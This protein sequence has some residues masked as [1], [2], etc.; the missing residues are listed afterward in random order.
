MRC[1]FCKTTENKVIDSRLADESTA[2]RR[3]RECLGC[4]KRFTTYERVEEITPLVVKKDGSR[5]A[6]SRK[7]LLGGIQK[8]VE[9]RPVTAEQIDQCVSRIEQ[10]VLAQGDREI[11]SGDLGAMVCAELHELDDVAYVRFAS[12][13]RDF[14]DV[15]EFMAELQA[16]LAE[17]AVRKRVAMM[18]KGDRPEAEPQGVSR[19]GGADASADGAGDGERGDD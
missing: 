3:R 18:K 15:R 13:Y 4:G 7:K 14:R 1:P 12:V 19:H 10:R 8:A 11:P 17:P 6:F 5:E 16:L 2:I 9:K